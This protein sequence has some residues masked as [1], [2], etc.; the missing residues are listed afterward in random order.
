MVDAILLAL[1]QYTP[2]LLD[3]GVW[4]GATSRF[5]PAPVL[6]RARSLTLDP[7]AVELVVGLRHSDKS[8]MTATRN[9]RHCP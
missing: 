9:E 8:T 1:E 4:P 7:E 3:P 5:L 6:P 2:W